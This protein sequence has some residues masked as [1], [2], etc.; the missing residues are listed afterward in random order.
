MEPRLNPY[1]A[2]PETMKAMFALETAVANSGLEAALIELVKIRTSQINGCA[3]CIHMHTRDARAKGAR[4]KSASISSTP[5][6][7]RPSTP[8]ANARHS[9]GPKR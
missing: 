2:A 1:K 4:R 8:N 5:G 7:N 3:F 6:A 9:A